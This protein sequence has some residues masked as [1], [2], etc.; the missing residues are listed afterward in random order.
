MR[1]RPGRALR[2]HAIR[3]ATGMAGRGPI[4]RTGHP[5]RRARQDSDSET[6]AAY[7][8]DDAAGFSRGTFESHRRAAR[9][10]TLIDAA[11]LGEQEAVLVRNKGSNTWLLNGWGVPPGANVP[12]NDS[13][14]ATP[15]AA[16]SSDGAG[17]AGDN[18]TLLDAD[19]CVR[20][21][22]SSDAAEDTEQV[23]QSLEWRVAA[24]IR[25]NRW[26]TAYRRQTI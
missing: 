18:R 5:R 21:S 10:K 11:A 7:R 16:D 19:S 6:L 8:H 9:P 15:G 17:G 24:W 20:F 14:P 25:G 4:P 3:P 26:G 23:V 13:T 22:R 1:G 2:P 12:A